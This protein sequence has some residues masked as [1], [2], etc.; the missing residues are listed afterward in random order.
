MIGMISVNVWNSEGNKMN[1]R[2]MVLRIG[3]LNGVYD[4]VRIK[5]REQN[6]WED[7]VDLRG[8]IL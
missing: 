7:Y 1:Q 4:K 2:H 8:D 5:A 3:P 6:R